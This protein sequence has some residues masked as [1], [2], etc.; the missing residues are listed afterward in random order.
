MFKWAVSEEMLPV[1][2]LTALQSLSGLLAGRTS[3]IEAAPVKP[4]PQAFIDGVEPFVSHQIWAM[5]QLQ[6]LTGARPGE[7]TSMRG[8][9]LNTAGK[10]WE[11]VPGSHKTEHHSKRRIVFIG[12]RAQDV[13]RPFLKMDLAAYLFSPADALAEHRLQLRATRKTP[14]TPSQ[15]ARTR[16]K[17]PAKQPGDRYTV[18]SYGRAIATACKRADREAHQQNPDVAADVVL[19]PHWHPHQLRHNNATELRREFGIETARAVLGHSSIV[20]SELYAEMDDSKAREAIARI[21]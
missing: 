11:Y 5:I 17:N 3:A 21:G 19:V 13:L 12:P 16:K 2:T 20:T 8:C 14:L 18:L 1:E 7:I 10:V 4:V 15:R 9:D 6:R